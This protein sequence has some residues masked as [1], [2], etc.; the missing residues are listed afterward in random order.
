MRKLFDGKTMNISFRARCRRIPLAGA[1]LFA[2]LILSLTGVTALLTLGYGA[3]LPVAVSIGLLTGL[4]AVVGLVFCFFRPLW[5]GVTALSREQSTPIAADLS[6]LHLSIMEL[7]RGNLGIRMASSAAP[8]TPEAAPE[9]TAAG[10]KTSLEEP[11]REHAVVHLLKPLDAAYRRVKTQVTESIQEFNL[12]TDAPCRRL[13]YVGADSFLEGKKCGA[14]MGRLLG[15]K[16]RVAVIVGSLI[17][18]SETLRLKG[19]QSALQESY[20]D[21]ETVAVREDQKNKETAYAIGSELL[22]AHPDLAGIYVAQGGTPGRYAQAVLDAGPETASRVKIVTHDLTPD[23]MHYLARDAV[24]ATFSQNPFAQGHDPVI[25]LYNYL[26]TGESPL[27]LRHL[28]LLEEVTQANAAEHWDNAHGSLVSDK[29]KAALIRA[30]PN[31]EGKPF[32]IAV[33]LQDDR[34]FWEPVEVRAVVPEA[35]RHLDWSTG[36]FIAPMQRLIDE[37]FQAISLPLFN[38]ELVP[39]INRITEAGVAVATYNSEPVNLRGMMD[40]VRRHA[41]HLFQV[42]EDMAGGATENTRVIERI[43]T[44]MKL[45]LQGSVNQLRHLTRTDELIQGLIH[46]IQFVQEATLASIGT[47]DRT[48]ETARAG[49]DAIRETQ[50]AMKL[51]DRNSRETSV[52]ISQLNDNVLKIN[53]ITSFIEN[54]ATQTNLLAINASIQAAQA[55]EG[56]RGFSVVAGEIR[57]LAEQATSATADITSL[58]GDILTGVQRATQA[59]RTSAG[60]VNESVAKTRETGEAFADITR[61]TE[62]N[63]VKV[64]GILA[65]ARS[66]LTT[67]E[68]VQQAMAELDRLNQDNG[69]AVREITNSVDQMSREIGQIS[70]TAGRL[71]VMGH[72][73]EELLSQLILD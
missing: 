23:T 22:Q 32:K 66:M 4:A 29:A 21:I 14:V 33:I 73:Q 5:R 16:G 44:T 49:H 70:T 45:L 3:S 54:I 28:T 12:V 38:R 58:I 69:A 34:G 35:I 50:A 57:R 6:A 68:D 41:G 1:A 60:Q 8:L 10:T 40:A 61:A 25:L 43:S 15:G 63:Q 7:A 13:F 47:A 65:E 51:L 55:G 42:S 17:S 53:E 18:A 62:E 27:I 9:P 39:F 67:S 37:G 20:P 30:L 19:F 64:S 36:A 48:K 2:V 11:N 59:V 26:L 46:S 72:S 31:P 24:A 52:A 71:K 56:G